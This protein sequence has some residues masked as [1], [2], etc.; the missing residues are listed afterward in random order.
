MTSILL[1]NGRRVIFALTLIDLLLVSLAFFGLGFFFQGAYEDPGQPS[2]RLAAFAGFVPLQLVT[3]HA[4]GLQGPTVTFSAGRYGARL[5]LALVLG[6][7]SFA[8]IAWSSGIVTRP[9]VL[10]T[11]LAALFVPLFAV[12]F[13]VLGW[14]FPRSR[15]RRLAVVGELA[16]VL[17]LVGRVRTEPFAGYSIV[18]VCVPS[19]PGPDAVQLDLVGE[20]IEVTDEIGKLL[21]SGDF[22]AIAIDPRC[23]SFSERELCHLAELQ[24]SGIAVYALDALSKGVAGRFP[25][26]S[27]DPVRI[28]EAICVRN[29]SDRIYRAAKRAFD[30]V[31]AS[32]ALALFALPMLLIALIIKLES[33]GPALLAQRRVGYRGRVFSCFKFRTMREDADRSGPVWTAQDDPRITRVGR[34]LRKVRFDEL[35]QLLNVLRGEMSLVGPRPVLVSISDS[36]R[37]QLPLYDIRH[38]VRPGVTGWAQ[39]KQGYAAGPESEVAKLRYDLYYIEERSFAFDCLILLMTAQIVLGGAGR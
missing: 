36:L 19:S 5:A 1:T 10:A 27:L 38:T 9:A 39:I 23:G 7:G 15:P 14:A 34:Y 11:Y 21:G 35:P 33:K 29:P 3:L 26:S 4:F 18:R 31:M 20:R 13:L 12:R 17:E 28:A 16:A 37:K 32:V 6:L 2:V 30:L 24:G 8:L 25:R 22:D